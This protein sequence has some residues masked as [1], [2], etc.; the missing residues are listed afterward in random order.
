MSGLIEKFAER[1]GDYV[2]AIDG[3]GKNS[4]DLVFEIDKLMMTGKHTL[5][6]VETASQGMLAAKCMGSEWLL[7]AIFEKSISKF[8]QDQISENTTENLMISAKA[9]ALDRQKSSGADFV[10][11]QLYSGD[12]KILHDKDRSI[13]LF[14]TLLAEGE[15]HHSSHI[16]AGPIKRK[17]NQAALLTLDL[18]RRYLQGKTIND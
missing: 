2:F 13:V 1:L 6:V 8:G 17:Q 18:L 14:N 3:L 11:V 9:I 4:G 15:F 5:A 10:I 7:S 12:K 16:I